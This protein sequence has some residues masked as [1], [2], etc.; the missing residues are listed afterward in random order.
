MHLYVSEVYFFK[1]NLASEFYNS[2]V[3]TVIL[4]WKISLDL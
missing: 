2:N 4:K 3:K 1:V